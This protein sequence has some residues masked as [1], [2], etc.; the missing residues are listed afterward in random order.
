MVEISDTGVGIPRRGSPRIFDRFAQSDSA[1]VRRFEGSGIGLSLVKEGIQIHGGTV[2]APSTVGKGTSFRLRIPKGIAHIREELRDTRRSPTSPPGGGAT[3][4]SGARARGFAEHGELVAVPGVP[5]ARTS[6]EA[7]GSA[8]RPRVLLVE[9]DEETRQFLAAILRQHYRVFEAVNGREGLEKMRREKPAL[10]VSDVMMPEMSG[11][12]MIQAARAEPA[13]ADIPVILLTA[14]REVEATLDGL[15]VGANDYLGKPFSPRELL[16]RIDVQLRLRET[17]ARLAASE[18]LAA[19][20]VITSGFAHE[21]RNPLNG[22]LNALGPLHDDALEG[23]PG[24]AQLL[25]LAIDCG[26]R[27][28]DLANSLCPWSA[29]RSRC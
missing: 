26:D 19:L 9:D 23:R 16:A 22:L 1:G 17:S 15:S 4:P 3:T 12:Q 13:L 8:V 7:Q 18:R 27:I 6:A 24:D 25:K 14:R 28:Q 10:V 11:L 29:C 5:P 21:V 2:R 20:G